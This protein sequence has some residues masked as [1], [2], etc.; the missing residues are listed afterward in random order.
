MNPLIIRLQ[1]QSLTTTH[2]IENVLACNHQIGQ[3]GL[4]LTTEQAKQI[5]QTHQRA[6][7]DSHRIE[8]NQTI[9]DQMIVTF[10]SSPYLSQDDFVDSIEALIALFYELKN[11]TW[12]MVS[13]ADIIAFLKDAFDHHCSGSLTLLLDEIDQ[14]IEHIHQKSSKETL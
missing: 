7:Q 10:A 5:V 9:L 13:D 14:Y 6:L 3:Y 12:D 1:P 11:Q 4:M 2:L 8:L